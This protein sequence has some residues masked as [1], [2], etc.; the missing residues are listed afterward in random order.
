[1]A[2]EGRSWS[3]R[4][5]NCCYL[6]TGGP[7]FAN[8]S[9][10]SGLD[11]P[12]DARAVA[13]VDWDQ[14]GDLDLFISNR[15]A[16]R[17][18]MMRNDA[19][20]K[21]HFLSLKLRGDG[22]ATNRDAIGA[23][24]EVVLGTRN[25]ASEVSDSQLSTPNSTLIKTLRAGEGYLAQGTKWLHFGLGE[26]TR[27]KRIVVRWPNGSPEE[28]TGVDVD[29]HY[30]LV[31]GAP[32]PDEWKRPGQ[33]LALKPSTQ[34]P[35]PTSGTARIPLVLNLKL[36]DVPCSTID[37]SSTTLK[38]ARGQPLLINLWA[39]WCAPCW[40]E[41][42]E[43]RDREDDLRAAGLD[44][45]AL[46]VDGIGDD[47]SNPATAQALMERLAFPF[48]SGRATAQTVNLLQFMHRTL[49]PM[50][51]PL[52]VP[53]SFLVDGQGRL[54]VIYNGP[55][56]V[57]TIL[58]DLDDI[59]RS[60][61]DRFKRSAPL[62]GRTIDHELI[63]RSANAAETKV[64]FGFA[65]DLT[66]MG[67]LEEALAQ[68]R[69]NVRL[70]PEFAPAHGNLGVLLARQGQWHEAIA[71]YQRAL[72]FG[73]QYPLTH[74]NLGLACATIGDLPTAI[75]HYRRTLELR[76][77]YLDVHNAIGIA[78]SQQGKL[79]QAALEFEAE[80]QMHP[81]SHKAHNYLGHL[82]LL[83]KEIGPARR[84]LEAAI[85]L[86]PDFAEAHN[87]LGMT[88]RMLGE[89][90]LAKA[91]Y[92]EAIRSDPKHA[93]AQNILGSCFY[94]RAISDRRRGSFNRLWPYTQS[95]HR[96]AR[97]YSGCGN[98]VGSEKSGGREATLK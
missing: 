82:Y 55:V 87:N 60:R 83:R 19:P 68:Y 89:L 62:E 59:K 58:N 29:K 39:S 50:N 12:D 4:E 41:L 20:S 44:I 11:F 63:E 51:R 46:S 72:R 93:R 3:G 71:S 37:G 70:M 69:E 38:A 17:L 33:A 10:V 76:P 49:T 16:P 22:K 85:R 48:D 61:R 67:H 98:C 5:R 86:K 65:K 14:D 57:D 90:E 42:K 81:N 36:P 95:S 54:D 24:V 52:P 32:R 84:A 91:E 64:R 23:R 34:E 74:Y 28:F 15:N 25:A 35:R 88:L 40:R 75:A 78:L 2:L 43:F 1:M 26:A 18:R 45:V 56:E 47:R 97:I 27:V 96:H 73:P 7:R 77:T 8:I 13:P 92:E 30:V 31:Q 94:R 53:T 80:I 6:N 66:E 79:D 21:G 9:A